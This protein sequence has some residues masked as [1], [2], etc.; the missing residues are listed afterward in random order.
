M[1]L[2][3]NYLTAAPVVVPL[4]SNFPVVLLLLTNC[5]T[6]VHV[7]VPLSSN[8]LTTSLWCCFC[9]PT[10]WQLTLW[11]CCCYPIAGSCVYDGAPVVQLPNRCP[12]V[13]LLPGSEF[14]PSRIRVVHP[15]SRSWFFTHP[16][17]Q[18]QGSKRHRIP[19]P[20]HCWQLSFLCYAAHLPYSSCS[21]WRHSWWREALSSQRRKIYCTPAWWV[22]GAVD[23]KKANTHLTHVLMLM[24][25]NRDKWM[26]RK[27]IFRMQH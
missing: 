23:N 4:S 3:S 5:R 9:W 25:K 1:L 16:G 19:D 8:Y 21:P 24:F 17:S 15:G 12:W 2:L 13:L 26:K 22:G 10:A 27:I 6:A 11:W 14:F 7:V 20:Q 18:I